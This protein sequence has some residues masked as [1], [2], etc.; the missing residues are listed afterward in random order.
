VLAQGGKPPLEPPLA[1]SARASRRYCWPDGQVPGSD[2]AGHLCAE[3]GY[4]RLPNFAR[5]TMPP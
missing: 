4:F 5:A 2:A 1:L 3:W